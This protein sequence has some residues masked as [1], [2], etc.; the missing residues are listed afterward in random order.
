MQKLIALFVFITYFSASWAQNIQDF[1]WV[2][3]QVEDALGQKDTIQLGGL[4]YF[5]PNN[6]PVTLGMD[7]LYG[8]QNIY[9]QPYQSLDMRIIQRDSLNHHC[10][11]QNQYSST[12]AGALYFPNNLD[13]KIDFRPENTSAPQHNNFEIYIH[14]DHYPITVTVLDKHFFYGGVAFLCS[15]LDSNCIPEKQA[16][17]EPNIARDTLFV[18]HHSYQNT[19][20]V[21][22]EVVVN[23]DK[24]ASTS[25]SIKIFP[26]PVRQQL[27]VEGLEELEGTLVISNSLGQVVLQQAVVQ[28]NIQLNVDKL[29]QGV[30][31][32]H[33]YDKNR[34][35]ISSQ[36]FVK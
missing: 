12:P 24:I 19:L 16:P 6:N 1:H 30:Y 7:A 25:H 9:G 32:V 14:A 21:G 10:I 20:T 2:K 31:I 35:L 4:L 23:T 36:Q 26:N 11:Q 28:E 18:L 34:Q 29:S 22:L 13:S 3:I 33:C 5:N 27:F 15:S 8:E 17:V